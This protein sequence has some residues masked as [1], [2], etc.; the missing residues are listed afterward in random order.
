VIQPALA[1]GA[2][3][4]GLGGVGEAIQTVGN[5][6]QEVQQHGIGRQRQGAHACALAGK[7]G[8]GQQQQQG[9]DK[10]VAIDS[11]QLYVIRQVPQA[12]PVE[13]SRGAPQHALCQ[14]KP[15][16]QRQVL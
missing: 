9:A 8:K 14:V 7:K 15:Q 16:P 2:P 13:T 4:E 11:Q 5:Q 3:G 6:Q 10:E 1:Y 12:L